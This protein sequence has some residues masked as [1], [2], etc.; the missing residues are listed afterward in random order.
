M[1]GLT[2]V[3]LPSSAVAFCLIILAGCVSVPDRL[4]TTDTF[5][6]TTAKTPDNTASVAKGKS[7]FWAG[8]CAS[9]HATEKDG[10]TVHP[11]LGG[12]LELKTSFGVFPAPNISPDKT[13]GIGAWTE[14]DFANA[15]Q[16]GV[17]PAGTHYFPAFP[18][19]SYARMTEADVMDLWAYLKTLPP[20][21][22]EVASPEVTF[23]FA[24]RKAIG[25]WKRLYFR[26]G[27]A[28]R[29]AGTS[30]QINR[31]QYLVEGPGHC[32]ECHTPRNLLGGLN[33]RRWLAG[34]TSPTGEGDIPNI[35][36][37]ATGLGDLSLGEIAASL[38]P[39]TTHAQSASFGIGMEAVRMNLAEL[40]G[41]DRAAIAAYLKAV[42]AVPSRE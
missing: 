24:N 6:A 5:D 17:A 38:R 37:D 39:G 27:S 26:S 23:P 18:Y 31:G 10:D 7:L 11:R 25:L 15:M 40:S 8:G 32:G 16:R 12:G 35:T 19:T 1:L 33:Y 9:C 30:P 22:N 2:P 34:G 14:Q 29:L 36:P 3:R 41:K 20:V 13:N 21:D 28:V 42:P 4:Q